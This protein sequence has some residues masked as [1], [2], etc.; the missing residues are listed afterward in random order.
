MWVYCFF[1]SSHWLLGFN[2]MGDLAKTCWINIKNCLLFVVFISI[3]CFFG[4]FIYFYKAFMWFT[5]R[6]TTGSLFV[7]RLY[8][9]MTPKT[10][11]IDRRL[12]SLLPG[13]IFSNFCS[14]FAIFSIRIVFSLI[15]MSFSCDTCGFVA[16]DI[17]PFKLVSLYWAQDLL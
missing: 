9:R 4:S 11:Q 12:E 16:V 2:K 8:T 13:N 10:G 17:V 14:W 15:S 5:N 6:V 7:A 1:A 3:E